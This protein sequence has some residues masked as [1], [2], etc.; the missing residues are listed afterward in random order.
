MRAQPSLLLVALVAALPLAGCASMSNV[1][2]SPAGQM[3]RAAYVDSVASCKQV[4]TVTVSVTDHVGPFARNN[5]GVRDELEVLARNAGAGLGADTVKPLAQPVNGQQSWGAYHCGSGPL[6]RAVGNAPG[7]PA[8]AA[9]SPEEA[10]PPAGPAQ[11]MPLQTE[12]LQ[13]ETVPAHSS[14]APASSSWPATPS[15]STSGS[16]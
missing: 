6:P 14:P 16:G 12:P 15:S 3:V 9:S 1:H 11:T 7:V 4:G 5:L 2:L 13:I 8:P 10:Q